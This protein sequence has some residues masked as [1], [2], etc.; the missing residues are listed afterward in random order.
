[1][2]I[3]F[4][5]RLS[6]F[7][8]EGK[9]KFLVHRFIDQT[10]VK[11]LIESY[12]IPHTEVDV[13]LVNGSSVGFDFKIQDGVKIEVFPDGSHQKLSNKKIIHLKSRP[14]GNSK[15]ICDVHLGKL[16]RTLRM[17]GIDTFYKNDLADDEIVLISNK[18]R[19]IILTRDIGLLKNKKA[20]YGQYIFSSDFNKQVREVLT[21]PDYKFKLNPLSLCLEC[22]CK[23]KRTS[24]VEAQSR[25]P[26]HKFET[27]MKFYICP[28]CNKIY[29]QGSHF[30]RMQ[31]RLNKFLSLRKLRV[32]S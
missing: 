11:D 3:K 30:D 13:I 5:K 32:K 1:L 14:K 4:Y 19:R 26:D 16:A 18:E 20:K 12:N 29:W 23:L 10:S 25:L 6:K 27:G 7:L 9:E 28:N 24:R 2:Y 31:K 8:P 17:L 15:F 22:G 21:N